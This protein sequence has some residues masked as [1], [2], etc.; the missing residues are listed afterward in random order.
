M[1][2]LKLLKI[3]N[4]I[5]FAVA[6]TQAATGLFLFFVDQGSGVELIGEAHKFSGLLLVLLIASHISLNWTVIKSHYFTKPV[7]P[8]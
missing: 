5:L 7:K 2:R 8:A 4:V 1:Q 3:T 6:L